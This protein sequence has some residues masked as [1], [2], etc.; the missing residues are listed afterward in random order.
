[1]GC[2]PDWLNRQRIFPHPSSRAGDLSSM[3]CICKELL[4]SIVIWPLVL[5]LVLVL[6]G[7]TIEWNALRST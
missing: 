6:D 3:G 7:P 4:P 1:M 2:G 5:V